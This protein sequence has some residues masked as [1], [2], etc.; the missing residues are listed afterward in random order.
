MRWSSDA[1]TQRTWRRQRDGTWSLSE[2]SLRRTRDGSSRATNVRQVSSSY[3][4]S[5]RRERCSTES[6]SGCLD[7]MGTA[8]QNAIK[9]SPDNNARRHTNHSGRKKHA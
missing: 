7:A 9:T 6:V 2:T 8:L 4:F 3:A 5:A 1:P